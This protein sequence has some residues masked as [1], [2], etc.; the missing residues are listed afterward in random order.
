MMDLGEGL[1][2]NETISVLAFCRQGWQEV[3]C[4]CLF[5]FLLL[6]ALRWHEDNLFIDHKQGSKPTELK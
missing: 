3:G 6:F 2:K 4:C 1:E 5:S